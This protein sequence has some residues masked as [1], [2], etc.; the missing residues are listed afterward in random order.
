M[1]KVH[2]GVAPP[3]SINDPALLVNLYRS[4]VIA[5]SAGYSHFFTTKFKIT[6]W[7]RQGYFG[8]DFP[9][10]QE[11][12]STIILHNREDELPLCKESGKRS[13]NC[14]DFSADEIITTIGPVIGQD[15]VSLQKEIQATRALYYSPR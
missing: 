1:W 12:D 4:A 7:T 2:A 6:N 3:F 9:G 15:S 8:G 5:K 14:R 10:I 11:V 13:S